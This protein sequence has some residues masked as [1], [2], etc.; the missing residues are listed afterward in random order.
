[1]KNKKH[2]VLLTTWFPPKI[3]VAVNRMQAFAK[4]IDKDNFDLTVITAGDKNMNTSDE[5]FKVISVPEKL[6]F[7]SFPDF[8]KKTTTIWHYA[9]V[10]YKLFLLRILKDEGYF[11]EKNALQ[12]LKTLNKKYSIDAVI[13]SFSPLAPHKVALLFKKN[14]PHVKWIADMR[15]AM[16][17]NKLVNTNQLKLYQSFEKNMQFYVDAITTVS[18]PLADHFKNMFGQNIVVEE[19]RNGYDHDFIFDYIH[20][21]QPKNG[22][23]TFTVLYAGTFYKGR[24]PETF[25]DAFKVFIKKV[26]NPVKVVFLGTPA[27]FDIPEEVKEFVVVEEKLPY[28]EAIHRM[29]Q[30]DLLLFIHPNTGEKGI[31]TG[32]LFDYL[33]V[34][35]PILAI[36]DKDDVAAELIGQLK[37]GYIAA[38]DDA[39][40]IGQKLTQAYEDWKNGRFVLP[41]QEKINTLHRKFQVEKLNVL[42]HHLLNDK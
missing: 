18:S 34:R 24:K 10:A 21:N 22:D 40:E 19:I 20:I 32:K 12:A 15:D 27:N 7:V 11:W 30:A 4:Y 23:E 28:N 6:G 33:S 41:S 31:F 37:A 35:K 1:M 14:N 2:I 36:C 13:S 5:G 17:G 16:S 25:F 42:L 9:K 8:S 26:Q 38:F 29:S 3:G 39:H